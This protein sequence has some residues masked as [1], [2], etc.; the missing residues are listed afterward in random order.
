VSPSQRKDGKPVHTA[1]VFKRLISENDKG[2]GLYGCTWERCG[3]TEVRPRFAESPFAQQREKA[4]QRAAARGR[5]Q[6]KEAT[7]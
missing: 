7:A 5:H 2:I 3:A 6:P 1:H 4:R